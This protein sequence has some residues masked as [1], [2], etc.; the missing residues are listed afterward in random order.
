MLLE[1]QSV[2]SRNVPLQFHDNH[3]HTYFDHWYCVR[4]AVRSGLQDTERSDVITT[5]RN[6]IPN[7][8][9]QDKM[10]FSDMRNSL[11][12]I[13]K[14]WE[15][16]MKLFHQHCDKYR[17]DPNATCFILKLMIIASSFFVNLA[18]LRHCYEGICVYQPTF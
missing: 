6:F 10:S 4:S 18:K 5:S 7:P 9:F 17:N 13:I 14:L 1:F 15:I 11:K 8:N 2:F 3:A 16:S 12:Q